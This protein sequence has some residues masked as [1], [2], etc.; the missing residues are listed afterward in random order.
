MILLQESGL[1]AGDVAIT[2]LR[3]KNAKLGWC[4]CRGADL[5]PG[6]LLLTSAAQLQ[7]ST[8]LSATIFLDFR[9]PPAV[10]SPNT[11]KGSE[12]PPVGSPIGC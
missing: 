8:L 1:Q 7:V 2:P 10:L 4:R 3:S 11:T 5:W 6:I 9:S 12:L